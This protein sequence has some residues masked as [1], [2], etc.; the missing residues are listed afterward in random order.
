L[1]DAFFFA[2]FTDALFDERGLFSILFTASV[3][4]AAGTPV[5]FWG[6]TNLPRAA[7]AWSGA[8]A[9]SSGCGPA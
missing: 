4:R 1:R 2:V 9:M 5:F 7:F 3:A 8:A 6:A